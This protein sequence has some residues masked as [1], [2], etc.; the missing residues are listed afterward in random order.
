MTLPLH[1]LRAPPAVAPLRQR[2]PPEVRVVQILDAA[3]VEFSERGFAAAR[4]DDIARRCGLSKGGLYAHFAGKE[5]VF[6]ALLTRSLAP[7]DLGEMPVLGAGARPL[8]QW[9]VDK[10]YDSLG[11]PGAVATLRLL[12]AESARVPHLIVLWKRNVVQ[13][14]LTLLGSILRTH[15]VQEGVVPSV[16]TQEPWLA[17]SPVVH[18]LLSQVVLGGV[19]P[20]D[21]DHYRQGHVALLC[22]LLDP[23]SRILPQPVPQPPAK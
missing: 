15:A 11:Q 16:I 22:E 13:P 5:D 4:M 12:V 23:T 19:D 3:L 10:L 14:Q 20:K 21:L 17:L 18:A 1:S 7:P 2:L 8:A 6:E 9:V